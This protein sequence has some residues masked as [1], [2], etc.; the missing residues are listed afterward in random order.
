LRD[1]TIAAP[2]RLENSDAGCAPL[3][4]EVRGPRPFDKYPG[5]A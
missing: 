2:N 3:A 1:E 4:K 5:A